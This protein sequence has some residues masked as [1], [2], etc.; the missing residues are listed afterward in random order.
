LRFEKK[1]GE[2][3]YKLALPPLLEGVHNVFHVLQLR[4][5]VKDENHALDYSEL[6]LH[7]NLSYTEQPIAIMGRSVKT[8]KNQAISLVL[9]SWSRHSQGEVTWEREDLIRDRYP[10]LFES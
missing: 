1:V 2:V 7:P 8:L 10:Q 5:Y 3:E 9:V 6:E 4:R